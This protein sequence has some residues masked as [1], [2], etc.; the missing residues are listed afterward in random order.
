MTF[1][2]IPT[3]NST[4]SPIPEEISGKKYMDRDKNVSSTPVAPE[5]HFNNDLSPKYSVKILSVLIPFFVFTITGIISFSIVNS[6]KQIMYQSNAYKPK[7]IPTSL[8]V[9]PTMTQTDYDKKLQLT[10][11]TTIRK[12]LST[13]DSF[14]SFAKLYG[15]NFQSFNVYCQYENGEEYRFTSYS[16]TGYLTKITEKDFTIDANNRSLTFPFLKT[17][18]FNTTQDYIYCDNIYKM[19][20]INRQL[21]TLMETYLNKKITVYFN[22]LST[23]DTIFLTNISTYE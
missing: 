19:Y 23:P 9:K 15:E 8:V 16:L 5:I 4:F 6:K 17:T 11:M 14:Y 13:A 12:T 10:N 18:S 7:P 22:E 1:S 21:K 3:P 2:G 20:L